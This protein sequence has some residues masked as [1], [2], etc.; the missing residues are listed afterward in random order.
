MACFIHVSASSAVLTCWK[1]SSNFG[2]GQIVRGLDMMV[3][4]IKVPNK[5]LSHELNNVFIL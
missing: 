2:G 1:L 4:E 5:S 3:P